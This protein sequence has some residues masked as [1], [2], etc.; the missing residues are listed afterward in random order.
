M[1]KPLGV[2][3]GG[4]DSWAAMLLRGQ[5]STSGLRVTLLQPLFWQERP[6]TGLGDTACSH[7]LSLQVGVGLLLRPPQSRRSGF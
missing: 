3:R 6:I 7:A 4:C 1:R 5:L 2:G